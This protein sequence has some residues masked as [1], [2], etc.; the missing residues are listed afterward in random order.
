MNDEFEVE[1][2][3]NVPAEPEKK[4]RKPVKAAISAKKQEMID[5]I[6][7][8]TEEELDEPMG[9]V[10]IDEKTKKIKIIIDEM[11]GCKDNY[12]AVGVNGVV[13]QIKRGVPVEV[14]P[15]VVHVLELAKATHIEQKQ[16]PMTGELEEVKRSFSAIP[17]RRA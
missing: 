11:A 9:A 8:A 13:Y 5:R 6:M 1:V 10:R 14:P 3:L 12:E 4:S 15:E 16:N 17:W 7:A 2:D